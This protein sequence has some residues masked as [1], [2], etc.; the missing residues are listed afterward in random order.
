M[1]H[2]VPIPCAFFWGLQT[3]FQ[4]SSRTLTEHVKESEYTAPPVSLPLELTSLALLSPMVYTHQYC[5]QPSPKLSYLAHKPYIRVDTAGTGT[6]GSQKLS[7]SLPQGE[8]TNL[9]QVP[10]SSYQPAPNLS[11]LGKITGHSSSKSKLD[12]PMQALSWSPANDS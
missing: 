1:A 6:T 5:L 4:I 10:H 3:D 7:S 12:S 2:L 11:A 8:V 9:W